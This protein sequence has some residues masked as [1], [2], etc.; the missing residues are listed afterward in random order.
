L[1]FDNDRGKPV[2]HRA[3]AGG[4]DLARVAWI[5]LFLVM[6]GFGLF[7]TV[8]GWGLASEPLVQGSPS[9]P[10]GVALVVMGVGSCVVAVNSM[11]NV[12][13]HGHWN[14]QRNTNKQA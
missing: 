4:S 10:I 8:M 2:R 7:L 6:F 5:V 9:V 3:G 12:L 14:P 11:Y 1:A 13:R